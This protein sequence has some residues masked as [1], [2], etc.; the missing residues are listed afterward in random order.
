MGSDWDL[1]WINKLANTSDRAVVDTTS[2]SDGFSLQIATRYLDNCDAAY[3][4][5]G[6]HAR[7]VLNARTRAVPLA[8]GDELWERFALGVEYEVK[9]PVSTLPA[10]RNPFLSLAPGVPAA[11]GAIHDLLDRG[12]IILLCDFALGHLSERLAAKHGQTT[13][14]VHRALL[15][16]IVAG[17]YAVPSGIFGLARAQNAGCAYLNA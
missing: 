17:G 4:K 3:G 7:V 16:G 10:T 15:A 1:S 6:H 2:I 11:T 8:L 9:D 14:D 12:A 5:Q 13:D